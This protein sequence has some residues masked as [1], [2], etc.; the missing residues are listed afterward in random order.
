[1]ESW[2]VILAEGVFIDTVRDDPPEDL[3]GID[4]AALITAGNTACNAMDNGAEL[5]QVLISIAAV[6]PELENTDTVAVLGGAATGTLCP[7]HLDYLD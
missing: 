2:E 7:E 6:M 4:D 3:G 1:M 5:R